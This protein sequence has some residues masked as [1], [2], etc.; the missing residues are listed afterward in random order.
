MKFR[1]L[2]DSQEE[3]TI[4]DS[5]LMEMAYSIQYYD[6]GVAGC[7]REECARIYKVL[8]PLKKRIKAIETRL[9]EEAEAAWDSADDSV[10]CPHC[11]LWVQR[12]SLMS[13][14]MGRCCVNCYDDASC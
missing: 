6:P 9:R 13:A 4:S 8:W 3:V 10:Q 2:L 1:E 11:G 5:E 12:N 7:S 14:S